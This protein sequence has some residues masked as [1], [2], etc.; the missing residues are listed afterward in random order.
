MILGSFW[1]RSNQSLRTCE[2]V[3][4]S[5]TDTRSWVAAGCGARRA[6]GLGPN[7][8]HLSPDQWSG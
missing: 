5:S 6:P 2:P 8:E 3:A 7:A 4:H 1:G